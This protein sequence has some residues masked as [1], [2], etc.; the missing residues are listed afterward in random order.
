MKQ[1]TYGTFPIVWSQHRDEL[2]AKRWPSAFTHY[3]G[4]SC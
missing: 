4:T 3:Y 1:T 2:Y